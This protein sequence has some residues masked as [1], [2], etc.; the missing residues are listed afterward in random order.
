LLFF[1]LRKGAD[2]DTRGVGFI[3]ISGNIEAFLDANLLKN[4]T[5]F[6]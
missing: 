3:G 4:S 2:L 6:F 1:V 5:I